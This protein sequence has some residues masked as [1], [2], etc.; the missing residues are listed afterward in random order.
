MRDAI[1]A[2]E[3]ALTRDTGLNTRTITG[4]VR[5]VGRFAA[6]LCEQ[7]TGAMSLTPLMPT[8]LTAYDIKAYR[9]D[10]IRR[11][12]APATVNRALI[13]L[14]LFLEATGRPG[15]NPVRVV[16][17]VA[18]I[19]RAPRALTRVEW[20]AVRRAAA[21]LVDR[22]GGLALALACLMRYAG[23]RVG[24]VAALQLPDVH[25]SARRGLLIIR[26]G[27]GLKRREVPLVLEAREPLQD[28]RAQRRTVADR[29]ARKAAVW[30][31][32]APAWAAWP[33]GHLF[34]GQRGPLTARGIHAII[35][36]L[37]QG[38]KLDVSLAPHD[39]RH[40]FAKALL[41]PMAYGLDRPSAPITAV[42]E[43]LG[44]TTIATTALYA[45]SSHTDLARLMGEVLEPV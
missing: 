24:E 20:A 6:W 45:R 10:L 4:Y 38:A 25:L 40:T 33:E 16:D 32:S 41:D 13:S 9:D 22:D 44:H 29:W 34:L 12:R 42:Q 18:E 11:G 43:L 14:G 39:L 2:W 17:R 19:E 35:A 26:R 8:D 21:H 30:G 23:P 36:K 3:A 27:K 1:T 15:R 5:D 7:Q 28:Y 37:G 31:Q